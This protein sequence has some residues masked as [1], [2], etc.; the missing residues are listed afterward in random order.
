[1]FIE[2]KDEADWKRMRLQYLTASD[3]ANYCGVNPY[4]S[5]GRLHL[6]E[7]KIGLRQRPDI[8]G[9]TSVQFGKQAEEH[10]RA[11]FMLRHPEFE[12]RYDRYGLYVSDNRPYMAATLDGLLLNRQTAGHEILEIKTGTVHSGAQLREWRDGE[13]PINYWCQVL[14]Q[15]SCVPWALGVWVFAYICTEWNPDE[16]YMF[17]LHFRRNIIDVQHDMANLEESA[18]EMWHLIETRTRPETVLAI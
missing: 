1:M 10:L 6:W 5:N 8:S 3:A 2:C 11:L 9:K 4:D 17:Q 16:G 12:L 13:L 14:H 15:L 18:A 7:E